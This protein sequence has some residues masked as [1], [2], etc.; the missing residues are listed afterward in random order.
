MRKNIVSWFAHSIALIIAFQSLFGCQ[1][2]NL[3]QDVP[4]SVSV[5]PDIQISILP[6]MTMMPTPACVSVAGVDMEVI[7]LSSKSA[8]IEVT[9]LSP[10]EQVLIVIFSEPIAGRTFRIE[11]TPVEV[12]DENGKFESTQ[13]GLVDFSTGAP[14][15]DWQIQIIH[16][17][18]VACASVIL[19]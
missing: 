12:A 8:H 15:K 14:V 11:E 9:G 16:S 3:K 17:K 2:F 7:P 18:G 10:H 13:E 1:V 6:P 19:P 4:Q 5:T